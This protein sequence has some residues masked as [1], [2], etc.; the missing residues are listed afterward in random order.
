MLFVGCDGPVVW[1]LC[2]D[3][4]SGLGILSVLCGLMGR[5]FRLSAVGWLDKGEIGVGKRLCRAHCRDQRADSHDIDDALE[6]VGEHVQR[7]FGPDPFQRLHLEV[8]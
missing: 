4:F 3:G 7:H 2:R 1:V 5:I 6:I 8:G